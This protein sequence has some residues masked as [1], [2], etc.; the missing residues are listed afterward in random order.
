MRPS[1]P[2]FSIRSRASLPR[3]PRIQG[4][5]RRAGARRAQTQRRIVQS[6]AEGG[7]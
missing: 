1:Q 4:V 5:R 6:A 7:V 3:Q 2:T